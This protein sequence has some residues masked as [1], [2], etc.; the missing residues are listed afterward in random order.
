VIYL[1]SNQGHIFIV[2]HFWNRGANRAVTFMLC[3]SIIVGSLHVLCIPSSGHSRSNSTSPRGEVLVQNCY[4]FLETR[5]PATFFWH[6]E[7]C[8]IFTACAGAWAMRS[9]QPVQFALIV[10][11]RLLLSGMWP[12]VASCIV[13]IAR[14]TCCLRR[15]GRVEVEVN[16]DQSVLVSGAHL[17]PVTNFSFSSKFPSDSC[18]FVIL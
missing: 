10:M 15:Q 6:V 9:L 3:R 8:G 13:T 11:W 2:W 5:F 18:V 12:Q 4:E 14:G 16:V 7:E 17:G 1:C